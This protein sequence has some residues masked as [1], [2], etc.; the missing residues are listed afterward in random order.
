[1]I[2]GIPKEIKEHEY[3]VSVTPDGVRELVADGHRVVVEEGAGDGSG[4]RGQEYMAAGAELS[5]RQWLFKNAELIVKVK[6]PLPSEFL[7]FQEGQ[8]IF[9]F[10]HL[11]SNPGL[12]RMLL[13]KRIA[14]FAYETLAVEGRLPLLQPMSEIAGKMAP[15]MAAFYMQKYHGGEGLL[16]SGTE[17]ISAARILILGSGVV[18]QGA[19]KVAHGMGADVTVMSISEDELRD[20]EHR[21]NG[22]VRTIYSSTES[23]ESEALAADIIIGAVY[24]TGAKTPV[25]ISR[26]IVSK[27]KKGAVIV[28]VSVD[29]GGC[30]ETTRPTT[31]TNPIYIVDGV[32]HYAVSNMPGAYPRT[33][34]LALTFRTL[35]YVK[36][37]ASMGVDGAASEASPLR[38]AV[39]TFG[40]SIIYGALEGLV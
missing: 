38:S 22:S 15:V 7:L 32:V 27:M 34:T 37:L 16:V 35:K 12:M 40:G 36:L 13:E 20:I 30:I 2:I 33:S 8:A 23:I 11:A 25:L 5:G 1:M 3:R 28:D 26:E 6:E 39:N 10:L 24:V 31:H 14:G 29:Q 9:T 19:L 18:G 4:F 21:Y 17:D